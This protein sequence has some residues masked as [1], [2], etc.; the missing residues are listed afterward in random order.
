MIPTASFFGF[1]MAAVL[2]LPDK[3]LSH[4]LLLILIFLCIVAIEKVADLKR[5]DMQSLYPLMK[6]AVCFISFVALSIVY[7]T[8]IFNNPLKLFAVGIGGVIFGMA[9]YM[10]LRFQ[11]GDPKKADSMK[12]PLPKKAND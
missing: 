7:T 11:D 1:F 10:P 5:G 8:G 3:P 2:N 6:A 12:P 4:K 9:I